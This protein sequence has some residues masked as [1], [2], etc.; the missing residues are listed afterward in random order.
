MEKNHIQYRA[1][2]TKL[3]TLQ[4]ILKEGFTNNEIWANTL[5]AD[6]FFKACFEKWWVGAVLEYWQGK[7]QT[8][9]EKETAK[10]NN[11]IFTVGGEYV[12]KFY[13]D[14]YL[15]LWLVIHLKVTGDRKVSVDNKIFEP[16]FV[17]PEASLKIGW[18]FN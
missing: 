2:R 7:I 5:I 11:T 9:A 15:N 1:I 14:F 4:F 17:T 6:Y 12:W 16:S 10:Y 8:E 18:Y 13:R 3:Y